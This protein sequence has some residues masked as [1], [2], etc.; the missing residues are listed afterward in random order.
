MQKFNKQLL[1]SN[2]LCIFCNKL[3]P[4]S[5]NNQ[6]LEISEQHNSGILF[7]KE[8]VFFNKSLE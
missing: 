3:F 4:H 1:M 7:L 6:L 8:S 2:L 5:Q